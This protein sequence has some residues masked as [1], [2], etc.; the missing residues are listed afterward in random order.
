MQKWNNNKIKRLINKLF[1]P[2]VSQ[3]LRINNNQKPNKNN[4]K[5]KYLMPEICQL[6]QTNPF[7]N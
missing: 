2:K 7:P 6:F 5:S 3:R 1:K 4:S